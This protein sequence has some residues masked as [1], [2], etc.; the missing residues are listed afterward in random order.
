[1]RHRRLALLASLFITTAALQPQLVGIGPGWSEVARWRG[2]C[3]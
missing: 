1:V 2:R 3:G